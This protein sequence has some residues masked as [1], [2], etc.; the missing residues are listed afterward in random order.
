VPE[1]AEAFRILDEIAV[2]SRL[3][4]KALS[5][6]LKQLEPERLKESCEPDG[7]NGRVGEKRARRLRKSLDA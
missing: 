7:G 3:A 4:E 1:Q 2:K 5:E 6:L